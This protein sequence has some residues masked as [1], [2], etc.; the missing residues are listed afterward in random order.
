MFQAERNEP[1]PSVREHEGRKLITIRSVNSS[2][3]LK[4]EHVDSIS[5]SEGSA[6]LVD[7]D[8]QNL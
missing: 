2:K 4:I 6:D 3:M 8:A 1:T 7:L 5:H